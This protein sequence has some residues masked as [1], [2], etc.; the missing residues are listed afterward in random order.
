MT[1]LIPS[2][3]DAF[4]L[5]RDA[6]W[7]NAAQMSALH[8]SV[9]EA[10][11]AG[12]R[13]KGRPWESP[14]ISFFT[15]IEEARG[16]MAGLIGATAE[17]LAVCPS[18]SYA[19]ATAARNLPVERGQSI[20]VFEGQFPSNVYSWR[21]AATEAGAEI[22]T[23]ARDAEGGLTGPL[24]DAIEP[25]TAV[26][27]IGMVHWADGT[28][29]DLAAVSKKA[30]SV[31][32]AL[33]LDGCQFL[34][35]QPF[36]MAEIAPDFIAAPMY[37]WLLGP[38]STGF[39][40]VA[41]H[42]QGGRPL[43]ETWMNRRDAANFAG[44]VDYTDEYEPGARRFDMGEKSNFA[45]MPMVVAAL[46][47]LHDW[48]VERI[49]ASLDALNRRLISELAERGFAPP[50]EH[51]RSMHYFGVELP[52]HAP[53]DLAQRLAAEQVF[54]S[55]RGPKMRIAPHVWIDDEDVARFLAAV[56]KHLV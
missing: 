42:R 48:G 32:A 10:G 49:G 9:R 8:R 29:I 50:P 22:V 37:K 26:V 19:I 43:E 25:R 41:P 24:L 5:P 47:L 1:D 23:V 36:D 46:K 44:L 56:D 33:V 17:D 51:L 16:L 53:A 34:G 54:V 13:R 28:K 39:L 4:D 21:R 14:P 18:A 52:A 2:Q 15:E 38:Y 31:G 3:R 45:L 35:A 40:Y 6:V 20:V 7:M 30:K 12:V 55:V 11:E 27:A